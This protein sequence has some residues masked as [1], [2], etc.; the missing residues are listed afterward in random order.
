[1]SIP[2]GCADISALTHTDIWINGGFFA[3]RKDI[4]NYIQPGEE[5]VREPFQR[6]I[7]QKALLA[8]KY[9]ASGS[10]WT[11][12]KINSGWKN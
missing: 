10:A 8:Y 6:L 3:M 5:L 7:D 12:S 9:T 11:R 4:F 1:M 2:R